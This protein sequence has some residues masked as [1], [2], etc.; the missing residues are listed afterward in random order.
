MHLLPLLALAFLLGAPRL[1]ESS[2]AVGESTETVPAPTDSVW[3]FTNRAQV[4]GEWRAERGPLQHLVRAY[5]VSPIRSDPVPFEVR[6]TVRETHERALAQSAMLHALRSELARGDAAMVLHVHGYATSLDEATEEAAE[7][8]QRGGFAGPMAVFS[9][10]ARSVGMTWPAPGR[11]FTNAYWQDAESAEASA[12]DLAHLLLTLVGTLGADRVVVSA[13]SMGNQLLA[14]AI[15]HPDL[16]VV[17]SHTPLRAIVFASPDI[18]REQ[19]RNQIVPLAQPLAQRRVLYGARDDHMLRMSAL[20]HNGRARAGLLDE[21]FTWPNTLE[22][23]DIT[24]GRVAAPWFGSWFDTNHA[25][26]R[27]GTALTDLVAIVAGNVPAETRTALGFMTIDRGGAWKA[28]DAPLPE[29]PLMA[30]KP[31]ASIDIDSGIAPPR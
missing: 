8:R 25:L 21:A 23:V 10:P 30:G 16:R 26:R 9:W 19:F 18:D 6:M 22:V 14:R 4:N 31:R 3:V 11:V 13:H 24:D 28:L 5:H 15:E 12:R 29:R 27:H 20:V 7:M 2:G 1:A 17:L